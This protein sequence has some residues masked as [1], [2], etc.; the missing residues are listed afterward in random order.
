MKKI[1]SSVALK[2]VVTI[3]IVGFIVSMI[4]RKQIADHRV[5]KAKLEMMER[6]TKTPPNQW[7]DE[8]KTV[9]DSMIMQ[10]DSVE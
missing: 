9:W 10:I 8:F 2:L 7:N 3:V 1:K 5:T 4:F 6:M